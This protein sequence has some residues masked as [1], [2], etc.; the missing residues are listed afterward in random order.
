VINLANNG[1]TARCQL[2]EI[3]WDQEAASRLTRGQDTVLKAHV[4]T[5]TLRYDLSITHTHPIY[6]GPSS[7]LTNNF[8]AKLF[9]QQ[10]MEVRRV[11]RGRGSHIF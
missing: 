11:V 7:T 8:E 9:L 10:S 2:S 4:H 5:Q 6:R 1:N 3:R